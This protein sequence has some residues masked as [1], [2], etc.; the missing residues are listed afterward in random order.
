MEFAPKEVV[1]L[2]LDKKKTM[3][4]RKLTADT[5]VDEAAFRK[6]MEVQLQLQ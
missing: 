5:S 1:K 2:D 6:E 3:K 4:R